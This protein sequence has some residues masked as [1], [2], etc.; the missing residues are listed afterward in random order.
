[1][2]TTATVADGSNRVATAP[3]TQIVDVAAPLTLWVYVILQFK[4]FELLVPVPTGTVSILFPVL[5]LL[6]LVLTP[7]HR[8]VSAPVSLVLL[9]LLGWMALTRLWSVN[10]AFTEFLLRYEVLTLALLALVVGTMAPE[11]VVRVLTSIVITI[12]LV[13]VALALAR[14]GS[15]SDTSGEGAAALGFRGAFDHKNDLGVFVVLGLCLL[16]PL[17][18]GPRRRL[19]IG[20]LVATAIATRSA[21][22]AG[23]LLVVAFM[24]F[25]MVT[26][27]QQRT[28]RER[29]ALLALSIS[30]AVAG[31]LLVLGIMP[32]LLNLYDKDVTFSGRTFI[33][34]ESVESIAAQPVEGYGL[35]AAWSDPSSA[36]TSDLHRRIGFEAAHAH[37][38]EL[39]LLMAGG[40]VLLALMTLFVGQTLRLAARCARAPA[41]A[42]CGYWGLLT[43]VAVLVMGLAEPLLE[44]P[45]LGM[46]VIVWSVLARLDVDNRAAHDPWRQGLRSTTTV[47]V[48]G[49]TT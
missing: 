13:S 22:V 16:L 2:T 20:L 34:A 30:A 31:I 21:T 46:L 36:V 6:V 41:T 39:E 9:G 18:G 40:V 37:N 29:Q 48:A 45:T 12:G 4:P 23:G 7:R 15:A 33:W 28:R 14:P 44:G 10:P 8:L 35:G 3:P 47:A 11:H 26:I 38:S 49:R 5:P 1:M 42:P 27:D 25:W 19:I 32:R 17:L 24:W 43:V